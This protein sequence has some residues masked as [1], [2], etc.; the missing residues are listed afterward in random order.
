[1]QPLVTLDTQIEDLVLKYPKSV[2]FLT[3]NGIRC[4][5]CGEPLWCSLGEL[6][7]DEKVKNPQELV[8]G[9]NQ[10]LKEQDDL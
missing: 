5:R 3:K 4:I 1:M 8:D 2:H 7:E 10:F 6:L 9:L